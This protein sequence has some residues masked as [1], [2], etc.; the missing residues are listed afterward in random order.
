MEEAAIKLELH[1]KIEHADSNQLKEIYG[2]ITDYFSDQETLGEWDSISQYQKDRIEKSIEQA[3]ATFAVALG[4]QGDMLKD[5]TETVLREEVA[6][7][8]SKVNQ[9]G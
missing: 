6:R 9:S 7:S 2:L 5:N 3:I 8:K 1:D 4:G